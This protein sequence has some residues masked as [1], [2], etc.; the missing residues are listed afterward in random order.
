M[1]SKYSKLSEN[2]K[3]SEKQE[4]T[5]RKKTERIAQSNEDLTKMI[6]EQDT[7]QK[8]QHSL[9]LGSKKS[10]E[11]EVKKDNDAIISPTT[12]IVEE[13]IYEDAIGKP[14]PIMNSTLKY[15]SILPE[16]IL[17]ATVVLEPLQQQRKLNE[18]VVIDKTSNKQSNRD[19]D[20]EEPSSNKVQDNMQLNEE[21]MRQNDALD[22]YNDLITDDESSPEMQKSKKQVQKQKKNLAYMSSNDNDDDDDEVPNTPVNKAKDNFKEPVALSQIAQVNKPMFKAN[23]LFSP[24]AK[25]SVKKRVEAFEQAVIQSP[26]SVDVNAPTRITRTKTRAMAAK[27]AEEDAKSTDKSYTQILARKSLAKAKKI[28]CL[29]EKNKKGNEEYK[30][31]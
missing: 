8:S 10:Q 14:T 17:N 29:V 3:E 6:K 20:R 25:E 27:E 1:A 30:E 21:V 28:A 13:S 11:E 16:K 22:M 15:S 12:D 4:K 9:R 23:A 24:Y 7:S 5:R 31:V 26:K 19:N 2:V 18:T